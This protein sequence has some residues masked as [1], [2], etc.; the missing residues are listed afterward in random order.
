MFGHHHHHR[1]CLPSFFNLTGHLHMLSRLQ[2]PAASE[3]K[4]KCKCN[5]IKALTDLC[6]LQ[7]LF[8]LRK[9]ETLWLENREEFS[10]I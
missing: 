9:K 3:V 1:N 10:L 6:L 4:C 7:L 2:L 5:I 8:M